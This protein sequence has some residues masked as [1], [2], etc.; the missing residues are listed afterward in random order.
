MFVHQH[1]AGGLKPSDQSLDH[2]RSSALRD[3]PPAR[4]PAPPRERL[5]S[6]TSQHNRRASA[7]ARG[8]VSDFDRHKKYISDYIHYY[9]GKPPSPIPSGENDFAMLQ[10][11]FRFI[12]DEYEDEELLE[13]AKQDRKKKYEAE[14]KRFMLI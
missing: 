3:P 7:Q 5:D 10:R 14:M 11:T 9:G 6:F 13:E 4:E 8:F 2:R 12:R 1:K